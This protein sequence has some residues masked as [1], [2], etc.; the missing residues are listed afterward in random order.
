MSCIFPEERQ[1]TIQKSIAIPFW[2][3]ELAEKEDID[4]S[5][6][7]QEALKKKC[8]SNN[9]HTKNGTLAI[10]PLLFRVQQFRF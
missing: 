5:Q 8:T 9:H 4:I 2:L 1:R 10:A 7:L 6:V 3:N